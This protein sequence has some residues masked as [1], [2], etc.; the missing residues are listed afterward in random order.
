MVRRKLIAG[1]AALTAA[2]SIAV[3]AASASAQ[4]APIVYTPPYAYCLSLVRQIQFA[5]ATGNVLWASALS[6]VFIYSHC[7][8]AAI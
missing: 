1:L 2:G 5:S 8:G 7:G 6:N 4:P 3:P